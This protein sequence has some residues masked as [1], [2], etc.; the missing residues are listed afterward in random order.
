M[1]G[2]QGRPRLPAAIGAALLAIAPARAEPYRAGDRH[3]RRDRHLLSVRRRHLP[4]AAGSPAGARPSTAGP[5][6]PPARWPICSASAK[7]RPRWRWRSPNS[8]Y[9]AV[10][11]TGGF[12]NRPPDKRLRALF[13]PVVET[14]LVL[15]RERDWAPQI[16]RPAGPAR[17]HRRAGLGHGG[18]LPA[19]CM[20]ARGWS[21]QRLRRIC[22]GSGARCRPRHCAGGGW[23]RSRSSPPIPVPVM[24]EATFA[25]AARFVPL[26]QAV[27]PTDYR[28]LPYYVAADVP[29]GLYPQQPGPGADDRR[30]RDPGGVGRHPRRCSSTD[31]PDRVRERW[32]SCARCI[33]PSPMSVANDMLD[34]CVFA[35]VHPGAARYYREAGLKLP[36]RCLPGS[37]PAASVARLRPIKPARRA[38]E[39][40]TIGRPPSG[41]PRPYVRLA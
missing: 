10:T 40:A 36:R 25:C 24:Q 38:R 2:R 41:T 28:R 33:W 21:D 9:D 13:S 3:R 31:H 12:A 5:K 11:G 18:H 37:E 1:L 15:T 30:A 26:D 20:A 17:E 8:L 32:P 6:A 19:S 16:G 34:Q 35:P 23:T 27:R 7:A 39:P 4:P 14:F 22:P 29:G